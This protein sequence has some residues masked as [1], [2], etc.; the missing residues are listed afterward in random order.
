[1]SDLTFTPLSESRDLS[2]FLNTLRYP[3][4][5][6]GQREYYLDLELLRSIAEM[7]RL[8]GR[9]QPPTVRELG[10]Q[11]VNRAVGDLE[12]RHY[13]EA[14]LLEPCGGEK[15]F[16]ALDQHFLPRQRAHVAYCRER[17]E[18]RRQW[19]V[20]QAQLDREIS[21]RNAA[22]DRAVWGLPE[23]SART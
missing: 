18:A 11:K 19:A 23:P 22:Q 21:D 10:E 1:M 15:I 6:G 8:A 3:S 2:F 7:Q 5:P 20:H 9:G 16:E 12:S 17:D 4:T 14:A 13:G